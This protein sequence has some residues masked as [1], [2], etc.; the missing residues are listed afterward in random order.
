MT[1]QAAHETAPHDIR[2]P[3]VEHVGPKRR[4]IPA[5]IGLGTVLAV[6]AGQYVFLR[7]TAD[8]SHALSEAPRPVTTVAAEA[9]QFQAE[10]RYVGT[11]EPW[12]EAQIGPQVVAAYVKDVRVRPG[13]EVR[14]GDLLAV[15]DC[16][17]ADASARATEA[18]AQAIEKM[19][20][21]ISDEAKHMANLVGSG[22]VSQT[23]SERR[24]AQSLSEAARAAA[25]RAELES[26]RVAVGDCALRAP[27]SGEI[28]NRYA[29]PGAF[30]SPGS[31]L[32]SVVDRSTVRVV[33]DVSETDFE[34]VAPGSPVHIR[35]LT[36]GREVEAKV[37]RRSPE[38]D[39]STR[40]VEIEI[41]LPNQNRALP[42]HTTAEVLVKVGTPLPARR[43]PL[44]A[45]TVRGSK[46]KL[47][48]VDGQVAHQSVVPVLGDAA[49]SLYLEPTIPEGALV[50][51]DGR[52]GLHDGDKVS[53]QTNT[54]VGHASPQ[55]H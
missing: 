52:T 5:V 32:L 16:R 45:A 7:G 21:A 49:G 22:F 27:F 17:N 40:T 28:G 39:S 44:S 25:V 33:V 35:F 47:F 53:V 38:A 14:A 37:T 42:I 50:V 54:Q 10:R 24:N 36:T 12:V 2:E 4:T 19:Q 51:T 1:N 8:H 43:V 34:V 55:A 31:R 41:D 29:D 13:A 48:V 9:T 3:G 20:S 26:T 30:A 6:G 11:V 18:Q 15:L 23:E 46:A